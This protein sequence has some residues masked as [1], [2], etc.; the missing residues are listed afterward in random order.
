VATLLSIL[1]IVD[2]GVVQFA[3]ATEGLAFVEF[4]NQHIYH[5]ENEFD[6]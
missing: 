5:G 1:V 3:N 2:Y 4:F 6:C